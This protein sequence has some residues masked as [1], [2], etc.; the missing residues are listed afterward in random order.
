MN[1]FYVM[2]S[3]FGVLW[4]MPAVLLLGAYAYE[5]ARRRVAQA[6]PPQ[7]QPSLAQPAL[8]YVPKPAPPRA[9]TET[10]GRQ[11]ELSRVHQQAMAA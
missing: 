7:T 9:T 6:R 11:P 3:F 10:A 2:L 1:L 5:V 4:V 8:H